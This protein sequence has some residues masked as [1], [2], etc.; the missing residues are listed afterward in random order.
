MTDAWRLKKT[1]TKITKK[2]LQSLEVLDEV[3]TLN[4][5]LNKPRPF[6]TAQKQPS[7][8]ARGT[9]TSG[10]MA[11]QSVS[12]ELLSHSSAS[13]PECEMQLNVIA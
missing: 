6:Q 2:T 10:L 5:M 13:L 3:Q 11:E 1:A 4:E 12:G 7:A 9:K 8:R